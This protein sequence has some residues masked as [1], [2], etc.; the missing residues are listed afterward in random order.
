MVIM[1]MRVP[2]VSLYVGNLH[3]LTNEHTL[4]HKFRSALLRILSSRIWISQALGDTFYILSSKVVCDTKGISRGYGHVHCTTQDAVERAK[5]LNGK[6]SADEIVSIEPFISCKQRE[7]EFGS[8][9]KEFTCVYIKNFG[10][11][12]DDD[13]LTILFFSAPGSVMVDHSMKSRGF[14]FLSFKR[15]EDAQAVDQINEKEENGRWIYVGHV[16]KKSEEEGRF[17]GVNLYM[18]NMDDS[19]DGHHLQ[20]ELCRF[21]TITSKKVMMEHGRSKGFGF[22][23]PSEDATKALTEMNSR[24][25][26]NKPLS[27]APAQHKNLQQEY[28]KNRYLQRMARG[29]GVCSSSYHGL[30]ASGKGPSVPC[31]VGGVRSSWIGW[32]TSWILR[33]CGN[34]TASTRIALRLVLRVVPETGVGAQLGPR[35]KGVGTVTT[36]TEVG[37]SPSSDTLPPDPPPNLAPEITG[38]PVELENSELLHIL[39]SPQTLHANLD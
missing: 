9:A 2:L 37:P 35:V 11:N 32:R 12:M 26:T 31:G 14:G 28:L 13:K 27:V 29:P 17:N 39:E 8:R 5:R 19:W 20:K 15:Q 38:M 6:M 10:I 4:F 3:I 18:N 25:V 24:I 1:D 7:A 34:F 22:V 23:T 21:R 36:S 16:Q 30:K 33:S